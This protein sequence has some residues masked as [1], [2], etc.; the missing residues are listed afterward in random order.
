[1]DFCAAGSLRQCLDHA[2]LRNPPPSHA[3]DTSHLST[4]PNPDVLSERIFPGTAPAVAVIAKV[5]VCV[6]GG[7]GGVQIIKLQS[8]R[9]LRNWVQK[10]G[11][12][13]CLN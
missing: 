3:P 13:Y 1:M 8:W 6:W 12:F 9:E 10:R 11:L 5:C 2:I 7:G 4:Q